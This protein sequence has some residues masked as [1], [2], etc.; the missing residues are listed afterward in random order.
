[1]LCSCGNIEEDM[2]ETQQTESETQQVESEAL[3]TESEKLEV[4]SEVQDTEAEVFNEEEA[5]NLIEKN[6][7]IANG[8][9]VVELENKY[10]IPTNIDAKCTFYDS[11]NKAVDYSEDSACFSEKGQETYLLFNETSNDYSYYKIK[12]EYS[13]AWE[14]FYSESVMDNLSIDYNYI[15]DEYSPYIMIE[16]FNNGEIECSDCYI[17]VVFYDENEKT[18]DVER[19][20]LCEIQSGD[21]DTVKVEIPYDNNTFEDLNYSYFEV[22]VSTAE[23]LGDEI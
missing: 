19:E 6:D 10:T 20:I 22:F 1:M 14:Y 5:E 2:V 7:F 21:S 3:Q 11:E 18:I 15:E 23:Y 12:Y 9:V 4:E 17:C 13:K 8:K 16:V